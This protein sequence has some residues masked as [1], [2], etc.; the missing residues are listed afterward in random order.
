MEKNCVRKLLVA[1]ILFMA[2]GAWGQGQELD[3]LKGVVRYDSP[4]VLRATVELTNPQDHFPLVR[5]DV[6]TDGSFE[7]RH[8]P[9][10][11]YGIKVVDDGGEPLYEGMVSVHALTAPVELQLPQRKAVRPPAGPVSVD[12]FLHPPAKKA[13]AA[14][15]AAQKFS[16]AGAYGK[17]AEE[18][19]K[20]VRISP[21]WADAYVNLAVQH[22]RMGRYQE[23]LGELSHAGEISKPTAILL[24]NTAFVQ[25]ML[26]RNEDAVR[27]A[28]QAL[29]LDASNASAHYL[30][31]S[32]L[33]TNRSTLPEAIRHLEQAARTMPAAQ[34]SLE[35]VEQQL[36]QMAS[37]P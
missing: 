23:A 30:L 19:E 14:F 26:H 20:A 32:L 36:A 25:C 3:S 4:T 24:V 10:G 16:E 6:E 22:I 2:R 8:V 28:R 11:T 29:L 15:V 37:R 9:F 35:R 12:Q 17:A 18:L 33:A 31:G 1:A 27:S 7:L 34:R 13:S 21:D 5:A